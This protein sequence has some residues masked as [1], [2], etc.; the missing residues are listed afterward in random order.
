MP[1]GSFRLNTLGKAMSAAGI[2]GTITVSST[3][4]TIQYY[5]HINGITYKF[6]S[7]A[8]QGT[9]TFTISAIT[10]NPTVDL[11]LVGGGGAG[12]GTVSTVGAGGGGGGGQVII[13]T[14]IPVAVQSNPIVVGNQS[15]GTTGAP[16]SVGNSSTGFGYTAAGGGA[17]NSNG[18]GGNGGGSGANSATSYVATAGTYS[19][20]GGNSFGSAT[21]TQRASG[22]GAGFNGAGGDATPSTGGNGGAPIDVSWF[23][24]NSLLMAAGGGGSGSVTA[25]TGGNGTTAGGVA[26]GRITTGTGASATLNGGGSYFNYETVAGGHGG[27]GSLN[28]TTTQT[29]GGNGAP[30]Y[31]LVRVP[32]STTPW[33]L[34]FF[35]SVTSTT[36][37][38][39]I[40]ATAAGGDLVLLFDY[41]QNSSTTIPTQVVPTGFT[42]YANSLVSQATTPANRLVVSYKILVPG[43]QGTGLTGMTGTLTN[44]VMV[45]YRPN[46]PING[47]GIGAT[48]IAQA[49]STAPTNQAFPLSTN[50]TG[51]GIG[52]A[53]YAASGAITTRGSTTTP[54]RELNI[55]T[56]LYVKLFEN[57]NGTTTFA[58]STVSMADYGSNIL[59]TDRILVY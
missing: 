27:A 56:N 52:W 9:K 10:G 51:F 26:S 14:N 2:S 34:P 40:P 23:N 7:F 5:R 6:Y 20:K 25:G 43:D 32:I 47:V 35:T 58:D 42:S 33:A 13:Q 50:I 11:L 28:L 31:A 29:A 59:Y 44:K 4:A 53:L 30:G 45:V 18:P 17:G 55:S 3:N 1:I 21:S 46:Q 15:A 8:S 39:Q 24:G 49:T 19:F 37:G 12:G 48:G 57:T 16:G 54:S 41:A 36:A 22:G 38:I